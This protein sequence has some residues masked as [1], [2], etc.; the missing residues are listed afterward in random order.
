VYEHVHEPRNAAIVAKLQR[1]WAHANAS[2]VIARL[3]LG[4]LPT[5]AVA[6]LFSIEAAPGLFSVD[7]VHTACRW[8]PAPSVSS[9]SQ[10]VSEVR[11]ARNLDCSDPIGYTSARVLLHELGC[12]GG[13]GAGLDG[14]VV[15]GAF[16][17]SA[18]GGAAVGASSDAPLTGDAAPHPVGAAVGAIASSDAAPAGVV[19]SSH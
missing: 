9:R 15:G 16:N 7:T 12:G 14:G 19:N 11:A 10:P 13:G 18:A 6:R 2:L 8:H 17:G 1:T 3:R 4:F 5:C